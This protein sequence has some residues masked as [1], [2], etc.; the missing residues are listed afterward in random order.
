MDETQSIFKAPQP[1]LARKQL[2]QGY[3]PEDFSM[4][5]GDNRAYFAKDKD[6]ADEFALHYGEGVIEVKV[7][8]S[9]YE[10]RL[11]RHEQLYQVGPHIEL[12][13]PHE[14]FDVL[15]QAERIHHD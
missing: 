14:D 7:P 15:N 13:I 10:S 1:G 4:P 11:K 12:P 9:V 2:T 5:G 3:H 6:L 8:R